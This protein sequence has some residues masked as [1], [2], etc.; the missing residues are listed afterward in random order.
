MLNKGVICNSNYFTLSLA[1]TLSLLLTG[2]GGTTI[3]EK[4]GEVFSDVLR[5]ARMEQ[6]EA[7]S[8]IA[9]TSFPLDEEKMYCVVPS[10]TTSKIGGACYVSILTPVFSTCS[11]SSSFGIPT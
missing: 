4:D 7:S 11:W 10:N 1:Q 9:A 5:N 2:W 8:C 3:S 6:M